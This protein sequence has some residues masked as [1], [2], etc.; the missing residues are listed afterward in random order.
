MAYGKIISVGPPD[1]VIS[2]PHVIEAYL[3]A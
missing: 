1:K 2:D 3:G